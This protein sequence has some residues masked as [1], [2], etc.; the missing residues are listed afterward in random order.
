LSLAHLTLSWTVTTDGIICQSRAIEKL[1][2]GPHYSTET[3]LPFSLPKCSP[4]SQ[5]GLDVVFALAKAECWAGIGHVVAAKQF[6]LP[7][8]DS[9][10][11]AV[12]A[13]S[14]PGLRLAEGKNYFQIT[15]ENGTL[16]F[17]KHTGTLSSWVVN[18]T[19]LI[20]ADPRAETYRALT[21]NDRDIAKTLK[22][23]GMDRLQHRVKSVTIAECSDSYISIRASSV[24]APA[25]SG[26]AFDVSYRNE[27]FG[28]GDL[29][30]T[31][32][33]NPAD[34]LPPLQRVGLELRMP[35][36]FNRFA[37]YGL[38]PHE[39]YPDRLESARMDI[40]QST[41]DQ[42]FV[43]R[44]HPQENGNKGNVYWAALTNAFG[45]GLLVVGAEP[46]NVTVGRYTAADL[47]T[48]RHTYELVPRDEI[49][50]HLD[51]E[52]A[53]HWPIR[54]CLKMARSD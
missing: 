7:T 15:G 38:G 47:E 54:V 26:K 11:P 35:H 25:V 48:A 12:H 27:F 53:R 6:E 34:D 19:E 44:V 29:A 36:V 10:K 21:D 45:Q 31:V 13:S 52:A 9:Q 22:N 20:A 51:H 4:G 33:L 3:S 46:L 16:L 42:Q 49:I 40:F 24:M 1:D 18:G 32:T 30:L 39:N 50:V 17:D 43:N 41:V 14:M 8:T 28:N 23:A 2:L 5:S 37:W